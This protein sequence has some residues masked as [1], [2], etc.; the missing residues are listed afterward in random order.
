MKTE[1]SPD[2]EH[3]NHA[4]L[5]PPPDESPAGLSRPPRTALLAALGAMVVLLGAAGAVLFLLPGFVDNNAE[6]STETVPLNRT[7]AV[8]AHLPPAHDAEDTTHPGEN[9]EGATRQ[10]EVLLALKSRS[11]REN[12]SAWAESA[13]QD[14]LDQEKQGDRYFTAK[15]YLKAEDTYS[16]AA[17]DLEN[18]LGTREQVLHELL[19]RG[20]RLLSEERTGE[21]LDSFKRALAMAP[22]N[23]DARAGAK[24]AEN[25]DTVLA[26]YRRALAHE[27]SEALPAAEHVLAELEQL[28][29]SYLPAQAL[30]DRVRERLEKLQFERQMSLFFNEL[31]KDN[32]AQAREALGKLKETAAADPQ[33]IRAE[34]MLA[35][36]EETARLDLLRGRGETLSANEAWE[37]ALAMYRQALAISADAL[38]AV[39]GIEQARKRAELDQALENSLS[40]PDRLQEEAQLDAA[41][42][43]LD[44]ARQFSPGGAR[45]RG[46]INRLE[47]LVAYAATPVPV[48]LNSDNKTNIAIYHVGKM[49]TFFSTQITLKPGKYTVVGSCNGFH[50]VRETLI[51]DPEKSDNQ[52]FVACREPI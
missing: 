21:A 37:E 18:L 47:T 13:Y 34:E 26:L 33:V 14:I 31:Q 5:K 23:E 52:L 32:L 49:G 29:S 36:R 28:D 17:G 3:R 2:T 40:Q 8:E 44:Y 43:L 12:V 39:N 27:Q 30:S 11:E 45:L 41:K 50:D 9:P 1:G 7:A 6:R 42:Q 10:L 48:T 24:I 35:A 4:K 20:H 19:D 16:R 15:E 51:V 46:Q 38:F 25:R 22:D